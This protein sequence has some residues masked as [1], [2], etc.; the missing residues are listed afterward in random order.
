[1]TASRRVYPGASIFAVGVP[2]LRNKYG[3]SFAFALLIFLQTA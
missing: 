2:K 1:M 3:D